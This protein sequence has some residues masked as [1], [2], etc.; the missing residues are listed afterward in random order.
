MFAAHST[1]IVRNSSFRSSECKR[2]LGPIEHFKHSNVL[3]ANVSVRS[4]SLSVAFWEWENLK[5]EE[6][7]SLSDEEK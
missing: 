7:V 3:I 5:T 6:N 4:A 1:L 2:W